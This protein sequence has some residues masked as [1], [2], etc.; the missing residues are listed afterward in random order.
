M[1][2]VEKVANKLFLINNG[3]ELYNGSLS[4]IYQTFG[5]KI[6][7]E[8]QLES[9][10]DETTFQYLN[11]VESVNY[12]DDLRVKITYGQKTLMKNVLHDLTKVDGIC[13]ITSHK[14]DLH[15]IFLQLVKKQ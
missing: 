12:I 4:G 11:G 10:I 2:L 6:I 13:D 3:N 1:S 9:H 15:E 5:K 14:P 8:L 7:I